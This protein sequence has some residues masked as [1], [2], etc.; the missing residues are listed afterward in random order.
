MRTK[1][2]ILIVVC[3]LVAVWIGTTVLAQRGP[4]GPGGFGGPGG[5]GGPGMQPPMGPGPIM[6]TGAQGVFVLMGPMLRKYDAALKEKG[7]LQLIEPPTGNPPADGEPRPPMPPMGILLI[8][9][10][11]GQASEKAIAIFGDQFFSVDTGSLKVAAK[12]KLPA[13]EL[14]KPPDDANPGP[15]GPPP[16][17][18]PPGPGALELQ[19]R[20]LYILRGPQIVG[21]NVDDGSL[22][23]KAS[24]LKPPPPADN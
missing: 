19:G 5:P 9:P 12:T 4:G 17:G 11:G 6:K 21:V 7:S 3:A 16:M 22:A 1:T 2:A 18:P 24:L 23:G 8:A 15:G 14:P 10:A 13:I 20:I